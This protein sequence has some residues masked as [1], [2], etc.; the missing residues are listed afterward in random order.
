LREKEVRRR[1]EGENE[2]RKEYEE[3]RRSKQLD[4]GVECEGKEKEC[5]MKGEKVFHPVTFELPPI[6]QQEEGMSSH[7]S[8]LVSSPTKS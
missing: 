1:R 6:D 3:R 8:L 4:N 7:L 5:E 2:E